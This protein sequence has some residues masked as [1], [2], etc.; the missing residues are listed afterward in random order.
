MRKTPTITYAITAIPAPRSV[1]AA[2]RRD[3]LARTGGRRT[4]AA[5]RRRA[6]GC[7]CRS[8]SRGRPP[9][10]D[11]RGLRQ[12]GR[13]RRGGS[14]GRNIIDDLGGH[15][16][17]GVLHLASGLRVP[18]PVLAQR[19]H[20]VGAGKM[21]VLPARAF[22]AAE[23]QGAGPDAR[24]RD[25]GGPLAPADQAASV[26]AVQDVLLLRP[27]SWPRFRLLSRP[28]RYLCHRGL[29]LA[30]YGIVR[31]PALIPPGGSRAGCGPR[32]AA[33]GTPRAAACVPTAAAAGRQRLTGSGCGRG[34]TRGSS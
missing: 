29:L 26:L 24:E 27:W 14:T 25:G 34:R 1:L 15:D 6:A 23:G 20:A 13:R 21:V 33:R 7:R 28:W 3:R 22:I 11:R 32:A 18:V 8:R 2:C 4:R 5:S 10:G 16:G 30:W 31:I 19:Q 17:H 12:D 9:G